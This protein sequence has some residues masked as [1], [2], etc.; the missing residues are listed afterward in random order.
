MLLQV[1][2]NWSKESYQQW[3]S[4]S[5]ER[6]YPAA[7]D[8]VMFQSGMTPGSF[9]SSMLHVPPQTIG[10]PEYY[11]QVIHYW[12]QKK[13]NPGTELNSEVC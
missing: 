1:A 5:E 7:S 12:M 6:A 10:L 3:E 2:P 8:I 4:A 11:S 13:F 9:N